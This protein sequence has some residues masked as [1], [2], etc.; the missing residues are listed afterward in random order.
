M[1]RVTATSRRQQHHRLN[2]RCC[3]TGSPTRGRPRSSRNGRMSRPVGLCW[4]SPLGDGHWAL[5]PVVGSGPR[6]SS[7]SAQNAPFY[8][9]PNITLG[10]HDCE[11]ILRSQRAARPLREAS[12]PWTPATSAQS[13]LY[14]ESPRHDPDDPRRHAAHQ[15]N[16]VECEHVPL[17]GFAAVG[18][19]GRQDPERAMLER[20]A[21]SPLSN[22]LSH[23]TFCGCPQT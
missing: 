23:L 6:T 10:E 2:L 7:H 17:H 14:L 8:P 20:Q 22:F 4:G 18:W 5:V 11:E 12:T 9:T 16:L 13:R 1:G 19:R 3:R 21:L 15:C